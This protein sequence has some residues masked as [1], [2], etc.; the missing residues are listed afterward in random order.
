MRHAHRGFTIVELLSVVTILTLL[1]TLLVPSMM[2]AKE[3]SRRAVCGANLRHC[4]V[5]IF[6]YC[7]Q[8]GGQMPY[9]TAAPNTSIYWLW[10]MTRNVRDRLVNHDFHRGIAYCPSN[11]VQN[12][13]ELWEFKP[14]YIVTGYFFLMKHCEGM[15]P[16]LEYAG[17]RNPAT[18]LEG[19]YLEGRADSSVVLA[20]DA[21]LYQNGDYTAVKG[22]WQGLH[23]S[24][25][26]YKAQPEGGNILYLDGHVRWRD[27]A[28]MKLRCISDTVFQE[29]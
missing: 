26:L 16:L 21:T 8:S 22:A 27:H 1:V 10:D 14:T 29:F 17:E 2:R 3:L 12:T 7:T 18:Y 28:D 11:P 4:G 15:P 19:K 20:S 24:N 13:L 23:Q 6:S 25:H 5:A 9:D